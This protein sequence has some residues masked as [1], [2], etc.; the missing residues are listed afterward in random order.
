MAAPPVG[1][2]Y[3]DC[4]PNSR[5]HFCAVSPADLNSL[6]DGTDGW[7]GREAA[8]PDQSAVL[9]ALPIGNWSITSANLPPKSQGTT[10][11]W[12]DW[13]DILHRAVI[14]FTSTD[15]QRSSQRDV[16]WSGVIFGIVGGVVA[17]WLTNLGT[18]VRRRPAEGRPE[19]LPSPEGRHTVQQRPVVRLLLMLVIGILAAAR[20]FRR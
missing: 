8:A 2:P 20:R 6:I 12:S 10:W 5:H 17:T 11:I 14:H 4:P 16:L 1:Q 19:R 3:I 15:Q 13:P 7:H 9:E 18:I